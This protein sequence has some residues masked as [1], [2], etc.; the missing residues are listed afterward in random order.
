ML[1]NNNTFL[2]IS[3]KPQYAKKIFEGKKTIELRK[4]AP[5]N[6]KEGSYMLIYVTSPV[7]ELWGICKIDSI[8]KDEPC[9][10]WKDFGDKTGITKKEFSEYYKGRANAYGINLKEIIS[11]NNSSINLDSLKD[12]IPGFM[13]PQTYRYIKKELLDLS[14]LTHLMPVAN[15]I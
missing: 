1:N 8:I 7:K 2:L 5:R 11:F 3:V 12:M 4:S 6:A 14:N 10:L 15:N 9:M 13:P